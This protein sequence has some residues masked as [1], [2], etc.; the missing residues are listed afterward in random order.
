MYNQ[1][2]DI[3]IPEW[4]MEDELHEKSFVEWVYENRKSVFSESPKAEAIIHYFDNG[5]QFN[6]TLLFLTKGS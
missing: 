2:E 5:T 6:V 4:D 3:P 1:K